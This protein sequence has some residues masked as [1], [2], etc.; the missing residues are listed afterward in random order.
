[1]I[2]KIS[3]AIMIASLLIMPLLAL[4]QEE[5][6]EETTTETPA[7]LAPSGTGIIRG[8]IVD[9]SPNRNPV[10]GV[11]VSSRFWR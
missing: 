6:A 3:L 4:A 8:T 5:A 7:T 9:T 10:G 1:M 2:R 11:T